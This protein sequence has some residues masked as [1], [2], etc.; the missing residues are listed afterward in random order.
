MSGVIQP[1]LDT[2]HDLRIQ[3]TIV[4]QLGKAENTR[5]TMEDAIIGSRF[6]TSHIEYTVEEVAG[7]LNILSS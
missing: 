2:C 7:E 6:D 1:S 5:T 4:V 3:V